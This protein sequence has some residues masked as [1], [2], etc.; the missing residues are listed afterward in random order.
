M[1]ICERL[2]KELCELKEKFS[3]FARK[4]YISNGYIA[5]NIE[6]TKREIGNLKKYGIEQENLNIENFDE[7]YENTNF[8][9]WN[10]NIIEKN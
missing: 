5:N 10:S 6:K 7:W 3:P 8:V 9:G 4:V 1:L 2:E